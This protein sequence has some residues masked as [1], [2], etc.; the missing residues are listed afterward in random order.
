[1]QYYI[2]QINTAGVNKLRYSCKRSTR[3]RVLCRDVPC[4]PQ[5]PHADLLS[6]LGEDRQIY[7]ALILTGLLTEWKQSIRYTASG[8]LSI[9]LSFCQ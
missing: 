1:M 4:T 7:L 9:K 6:A 3:A 2:I 8:K 5:T